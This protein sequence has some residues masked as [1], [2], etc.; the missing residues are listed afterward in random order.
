LAPVI[1]S[2]IFSV[3]EDLLLCDPTHEDEYKTVDDTE[4]TISIVGL[5]FNFSLEL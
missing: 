2:L 3:V 1:D 5:K 4:E